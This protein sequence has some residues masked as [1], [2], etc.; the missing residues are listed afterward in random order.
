MEELGQ[1]FKSGLLG[2][3]DIFYINGNLHVPLDTFFFVL[4]KSYFSLITE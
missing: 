2:V 4:Q 1:W 3:N